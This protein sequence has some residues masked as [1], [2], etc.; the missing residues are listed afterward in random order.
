MLEY[1]QIAEA[2]CIIHLRGVESVILK[3]KS[4]P[5]P[6]PEPGPEPGP[7]K[8]ISPS[9]AKL[10]TCPDCKDEKIR[11]ESPRC[12]SCAS[13]QQTRKVPDRPSLLQLEN[14]LEELGSYAA[15]GR[16]YSVAPTT[17]KKWIK[18]YCN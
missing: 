16:K 9:K 8:K 3:R 15:M 10:K 4:E 17:I 5:E 7:P 6:E 18:G 14:D 11:K 2:I 1:V 13:K 12:R